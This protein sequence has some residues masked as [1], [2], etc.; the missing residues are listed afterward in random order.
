MCHDVWACLTMTN[1][2]AQTDWWSL[3]HMK[4]LMTPSECW[5]ALQLCMLSP[6]V[7]KWRAVKDTMARR[8]RNFTTSAQPARPERTRQCSCL[9]VSQRKAADLQP[10]AAATCSACTR[11]HLSGKALGHQLAGESLRDR[12][13]LGFHNSGRLLLGAPHV[14]QLRLGGSGRHPLRCQ[15]LA[16]LPCHLL[17]PCGSACA[18]SCA[19]QFSIDHRWLK[20]TI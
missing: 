12:Q 11:E 13:R 6:K 17:A 1:T 8:R 20:V 19:K 14:C 16:H 9:P 10:L 18:D 7:P 5:K 2:K 3:G 4:H 15:L